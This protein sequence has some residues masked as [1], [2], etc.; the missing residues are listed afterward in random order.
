MMMH[1]FAALSNS[2]AMICCNAGAAAAVPLSAFDV[3]C[4]WIVYAF[5]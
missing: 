1:D 3:A 4:T 5:C 2:V